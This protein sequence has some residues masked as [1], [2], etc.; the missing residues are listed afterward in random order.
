MDA[1]C[2]RSG[3]QKYWT[4][5]ELSFEKAIE[6]DGISVDKSTSEGITCATQV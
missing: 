4:R 3:G 6:A 5:L 1:N 2:T